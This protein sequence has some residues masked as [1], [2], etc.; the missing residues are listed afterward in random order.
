MVWRLQ[1]E[2]YLRHCPE[3]TYKELAREGY[4]ARPTTVDRLWNEP[5]CGTLL[6]DRR[7]CLR[8]H[9]TFPSDEDRHSKRAVEEVRDDTFYFGVNLLEEADLWPFIGDH[10]V[11]TGVEYVVQEVRLDPE[12]F[13]GHTNI[14]LHVT[15]LC[16]RFRYG[17]A[18][19]PNTLL[20]MEM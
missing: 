9:V 1:R 8:T 2:W 5:N 10:I 12:N 15:C 13:W 18:R 19:V 4:N 6:F 17:D 16:E 14:P 11:F 20:A 7:L 3:V